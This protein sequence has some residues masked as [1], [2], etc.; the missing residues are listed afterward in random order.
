MNGVLPPGIH[1]ASVAEVKG[2]FAMDAWR[3]GLFG[4]LQLALSDLKIARCS[5]VWLDGSFV[6]AKKE[7]RDFDLCWDMDGVDWNALDPV[8]LMVQ[9]PRKEQ[10]LKY[11]GDVLPNV[12]ESGSGK[13][14]LDFFQ[15]DKSIGGI[16][17]IIE[18]TI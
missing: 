18:L 1:A 2:T 14:I 5:R 11:R 9:P 10:S 16:K 13:L 17:G 8:L 7:P 12:T 15:Q 3:I 6:T 4:G